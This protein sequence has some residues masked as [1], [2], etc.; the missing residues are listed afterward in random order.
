MAVKTFRL[1]VD[2]SGN[3]GTVDEVDHSVVMDFGWTVAKIAAGL[4]SEWKASAG[5]ASGS[6]TS[7]TTTPKPASLLTG[8]GVA[9]AMRTLNPLTG[10]FAATNWTFTFAMRAGISSSQRGRMRVRVYKSANA[11]GTSGVTELTGATLVSTT[12][13][14]IAT[15]GETIVTV[16]WSPG[17]IA[18]A[19]EYLFF[20]LAWET[21]T[22]GGSNSAD[23]RPLTGST[24][25]GTRIA[26]P[27]FVEGP[28]SNS[29]APVVAGGEAIV[30][31]TL[32]CS[33]GTWS[34]TSPTYAYQ[35]RRDGVDISGATAS[36][37]LLVS[38]DEGKSIT[39]RVTATTSGGS[40]SADSSNTV[41]PVPGPDETSYD[42]FN[43][44]DG[45]VYAG[46]G[47]TLWTT[48]RLDWDQTS[49]AE[50]KF[51]TLG[52]AVTSYEQAVSKGI[53]GA[54]GDFDFVLN[55]V[56]TAISPGEIAIWFC[57]TGHG[58]AAAVNGYAFIGAS[59]SN[60]WA[61][62]KY[63]GGVLQGTIAGPNTPPDGALVSGDTI[64][65]SK[66]GTTFKVL[67]KKSGNW[68]TC[69]QVTDATYSSGAIAIEMSDTNVRWDN[70]RGGPW[71]G[72][73]PP[74]TMVT[75]LDSSAGSEASALAPRL[76]PAEV[77]AGVDLAVLTAAAKAGLDVGA[78][79]AELSALLAGGYSS[80]DVA[81]GVDA[82]ALQVML[83]VSD[84]GTEAEA[85]DKV[86]RTLRTV[87]VV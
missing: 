49:L 61:I 75:S 58:P 83:A 55:C 72:I 84:A 5:Q 71:T 34:G 7:Q 3:F 16:T 22:A 9:N 69:V 18:L 33:Q 85:A 56:S 15:T 36:S 46:A 24:T 59:L 28:P 2:L 60:Y 68:V 30:G 82:T 77:G 39:C 78:G 20:A 67:R 1:S 14:V 40:T 74:P 52:Q 6:F 11:A 19:N 13:A 17:A 86:N 29:V 80:L 87:A 38:A 81:A 54:D 70:V 62:R 48:E 45:P 8:L 26:T 32:S 47:A 27:D 53:L 44:A 64:W 73:G 66:R 57:V 31:N 21:T 23:A 43:R 12:S 35:W 10:T 63:T 79:S 42:D 37:Y 41:T 50:V 25:A 51:N 4:S 65:I 76:V